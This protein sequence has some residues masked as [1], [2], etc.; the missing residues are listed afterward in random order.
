MKSLANHLKSVLHRI[1]Y[2]FTIT[3]PIL[4]DI[5][6]TF[7]YTYKAAKESNTVIKQ[8]MNYEVNDD[9]IGYLAL[10]LISAIDR[11]KS[12]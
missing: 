1:N 3:N 2:G 7:P 11:S 4:N 6:R 5:K 8:L 10:Y 12:P 9:E